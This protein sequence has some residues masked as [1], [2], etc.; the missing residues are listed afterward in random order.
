MVQSL[1]SAQ[2]IDLVGAG[3]AHE[4]FSRQS[5]ASTC[6]TRLPVISQLKTLQ[7]QPEQ[8][9]DGRQC[10]IEPMVAIEQMNRTTVFARKPNAVV[11]W[12]DDVAPAV[13]DQRRR[14]D[15]HRILNRV[16]GQVKGR[17][18]P[19]Q[20]AQIVADRI[21]TAIS[22]TTRPSSLAF[23]MRFRF[24]C[25]RPIRSETL[26]VQNFP[27]LEG[28]PASP[29]LASLVTPAP[30]RGRYVLELF[31]GDSLREPSWPTFA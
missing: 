11:G 26:N 24:E 28:T 23:V 19:L 16:P 27:F 8:R 22:T 7:K 17:R 4:V 21:P 12:H 3:L 31:H 29:H 5:P 30:S 15:R 20:I 9:L 10:R 2:S 6:V 18:Q 25:W 1:R 14:S 13:H